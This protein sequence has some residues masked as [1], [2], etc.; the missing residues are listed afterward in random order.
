MTHRVASHEEPGPVAPRLSVFFLTSRPDTSPKDQTDH[1]PSSR[2]VIRC[3][4][5]RGNALFY[6]AV[7]D[8]L[9]GITG[10]TAAI[11]RVPRP[12]VVLLAFSR[13][14]SYNRSRLP[15][16]R[17]GLHEKITKPLNRQ[18]FVY[19]GWDDGSCGSRARRWCFLPFL[20]GARIT[21]PGFPHEPSSRA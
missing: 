17:V 13:W 21:A 11:E 15:V 8:L 20:A 9:A 3:A 4:A 1:D 14:R 2:G 5:P 16:R 10:N 6:C 7:S 19:P 12:S 18:S